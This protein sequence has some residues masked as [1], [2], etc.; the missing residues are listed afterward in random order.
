MADDGHR[1]L[2]LLLGDALPLGY[3]SGLEDDLRP[4]LEVEAQN[5]PRVLGHRDDEVA[6][7]HY[8]H[9]HERDGIR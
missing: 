8:H 7:R 5:R 4:A 2:Q 6:E 9:D 1:L 3:G